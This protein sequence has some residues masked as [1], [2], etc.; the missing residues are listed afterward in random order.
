VRR[1]GAVR[2]RGAAVRCGEAAARRAARLRLG[3]GLAA[4]WL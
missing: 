4:V 2:R 3:C 1:G